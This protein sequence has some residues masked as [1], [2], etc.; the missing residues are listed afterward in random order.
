M[1][2]VVL[3]IYAWHL[4]LCCV[5]LLCLLSFLLFE[6]RGSCKSKIRSFTFDKVNV[7]KPVVDKLC[8]VLQPDFDGYLFYVRC[9][10]HIINLI[11]Q[12]GLKH[13]KNEIQRIKDALIYI[14]ISPSIK[15][16][17]K[18]FCAEFEMT[19]MKIF[20]SD[21]GYRWNSTYLKLKSCK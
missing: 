7:N 4:K 19:V 18:K 12:D 2:L 10:Y 14:T 21:V 8:R 3:L 1:T 16:A 11:L 9:V 13:I 20:V 15:Q 6:I 17:F 5:L